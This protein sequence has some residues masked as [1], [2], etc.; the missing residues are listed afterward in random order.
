MMKRRLFGV[1]IMFVGMFGVVAFQPQPAY[2]ACTDD[3]MGIPAW[4]RGLQE[5]DCSVSKPA[6]DD[7]GDGLKKFIWKIVLNII[8]A[9]LMIVAYV[10]I[11]YLLIGGF[12]YMTST[13]DQSGM[14]T[15]KKT[16]TNAIIG[17]VIALLSASIVNAIA[18]LIP[19]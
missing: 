8:Q 1:F 7:N 6:Q 12:K 4:Y 19:K 9:A 17:L 15:A 18:G 13:G 2:A 11:I 10:T 14:T 3:L 16:V 5:P